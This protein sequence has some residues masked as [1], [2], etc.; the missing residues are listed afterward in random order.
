MATT[1]ITTSAGQD[2]KLKTAAEYSLDHSDT[3]TAP[4]TL[5]ATQVKAFWRREMVGHMKSRVRRLLDDKKRDDD[6]PADNVDDIT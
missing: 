1:T 5:T 6:G 2:G 3:D 4:H